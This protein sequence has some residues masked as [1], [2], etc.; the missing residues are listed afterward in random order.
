LPAA[1]RHDELNQKKLL[2]NQTAVGAIALGRAGGEMY[3]AQSLG[4][5][6][7]IVA[8]SDIGGQGLA[9]QRR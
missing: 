5:P 4:A 6:T 3:P 2:V 9:D 1:E 8:A 7:E